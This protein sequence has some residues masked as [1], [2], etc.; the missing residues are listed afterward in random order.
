MDKPRFQWV[1]TEG[2]GTEMSLCAPTSQPTRLPQ[3][4]EPVLGFYLYEH[5]EINP[6]A[7]YEGL[8]RITKAPVDLARVNAYLADTRLALRPA[9]PDRLSITDVFRWVKHLKL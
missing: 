7:F 8:K 5:P 1:K 9:D 4:I 2:D 6:Q 3:V